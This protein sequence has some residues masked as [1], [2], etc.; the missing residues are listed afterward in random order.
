[1]KEPLAHAE[2]LELNEIAAKKNRDTLKGVLIAGL[3]PLLLTGIGTVIVLWVRLSPLPDAF[4]QLRDNVTVTQQIAKDAD[5]TA[6][7]AQIS[8]NSA[9][10][11]AQEDH[12]DDIRLRQE[13][14]EHGWK[15]DGGIK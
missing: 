2:L 14:I 15:L 13:A 10:E 12:E 11:I 8:A 1:M 4:A 3:L 5:K 9:I 7:A 6:S